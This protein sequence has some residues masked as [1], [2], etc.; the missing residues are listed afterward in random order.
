MTKMTNIEKKYFGPMLIKIWVIKKWKM[1]AILKELE[2][3]H[4]EVIFTIP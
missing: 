2:R 4:E 1:N 3:P